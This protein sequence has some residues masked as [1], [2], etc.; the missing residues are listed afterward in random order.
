M[1]ETKKETIEQLEEIKEEIQEVAPQ[2]DEVEAK[3]IER[4][5]KNKKICLNSLKIFGISLGSALFA[6]FFMI[7]TMFIFAPK[8]DAKI[9]NFFGLKKAEEA[10]YIR[11][12]EKSGSNVDL[13]NLIVL[14]S[15][16]E[17][18]EKELM[19]INE[20]V[21]KEDYVDFY[22]K[23][24]K[25]AISAVKDKELIALTCNTNGYLV[26][27]KVKCM[28]ELGFSDVNIF[29]Y[30]K[31]QL[32]TDFL[33]DGSFVSYV[34]LV[35]NN[36]DLTKETKQEKFENLYIY[37]GIDGLLSSKL[38]KLKTYVEETTSKEGKIIAQ[39]TIMNIRK[40]DYMIDVINE[41]EELEISEAAY[42]AE[43]AAYNELIK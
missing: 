43:L 30:I 18:Y 16:F 17:N 41:S 6:F 13:Y 14:E 5:E 35:Y 39:N 31:S 36:N 7:S 42:K 29:A 8:F 20:L 23:L 38:T 24:D 10:C 4:K 34:E 15:K 32:E 37:N 19:Y 1:K 28:Y 22:T 21:T 25:S 9:F 33:F 12:Y 2:I 11:I 40:A 26:N 3:I 27:Q